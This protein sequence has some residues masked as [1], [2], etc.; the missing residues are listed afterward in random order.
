MDFL[1]LLGVIKWTPQDDAQYPILDFRIP[2]KQQYSIGSEYAQPTVHNGLL[3]VGLSIANGIFVYEEST[4][5]FLFH[6]DTA[7]TVQ[8]PPVIQEQVLYVADTAGGI[9]A[10]DLSTNSLLW[11]KETNSPIM[12]SMCLEEDSILFST[13]GNSVYRISK[14]GELLW[15]YQYEAKV[16]RAGELNIFGGSAPSVSGDFV[17][18][19][20]SDGAVQQISLDKGEVGASVWVGEGR[21][22]DIVSKVAIVE[23]MVIVS[24]FELPT[25]AYDKDLTTEKW[26]IE[27]GRSADIVVNSNTLYLASSDGIL[28]AV[29]VL[30][31]A[32]IW[33]WDS[34]L[35]TNLTTPIL[36]GETLYLG[37]VAGSLYGINKDN[38]TLV[39]SYKEET[40]DIGFS[41]PIRL[42]SSHIFAISNDR[43]LYSFQVA[44]NTEKKSPNLS[45]S[46]FESTIGE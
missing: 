31:G 18:V 39:W 20:F 7:A 36:L 37:S 9:Y 16:S 10:F 40:L 19:G 1:M 3:Y 44:K 46:M 29:D 23:D 12:S 38:G 32:R 6:F 28:R 24:G 17:Y 8:V 25:I 13:V 5:S 11:K 45:F 2:L 14:N 21:Y 35:K 42:D 43:V 27:A 26:R 22:P 30:S 34:T 4:G 41:A 15:R 33:E